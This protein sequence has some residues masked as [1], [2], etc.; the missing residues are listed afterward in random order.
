[1]KLLRA[2]KQRPAMMRPLPCAEEASLAIKKARLYCLKA[3]EWPRWPCQAQLCEITICTESS[4]SG[5]KCGE[6]SNSVQMP[7][8]SRLEKGIGLVSA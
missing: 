5:A 7:N 6:N 8:S 4:P 1:M 2:L 3:D